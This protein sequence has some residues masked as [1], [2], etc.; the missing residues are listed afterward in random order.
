M[1]L[2]LALS[3]CGSLSPDRWTGTVTPEGGPGCGPPSSATLTRRGHEFAF[4]PNDGALVI[5]GTVG[6][7]GTLHGTLPNTDADHK[8][9]PLTLDGTLTPLGF[10]GV[11]TTPR[12]RAQV[13]LR[14]P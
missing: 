12:C 1:A 13:S 3:G 6:A 9:F 10:D 11:Y 8:P 2:G 14:R 4:A 5:S 7:D